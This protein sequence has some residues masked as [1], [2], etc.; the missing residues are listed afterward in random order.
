MFKPSPPSV[1]DPTQPW[2]CSWRSVGPFAQNA[3]KLLE[4]RRV[5]DGL[6]YASIRW[7]PYGPRQDEYYPHTL[8]AGCVRFMDIAVPYQPDRCL[9][10]FGHVQVITNPIMR[11]TAHRPASGIGYEVSV[12]AVGDHLWDCWEDHLVHLSRRSR[13]VTFPGET[14]PDYEDWYNGNS[15]PLIIDPEHHDAPTAHDDVDVTAETPHA[16][17]DQF[18]QA[19]RIG[20]DKKQLSFFRNMM[21]NI[22]PLIDRARH[23]QSTRGPRQTPGD[24]IQRRSLGVYTDSEGEG[25]E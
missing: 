9:R 10:Q 19:Q 2:A 6:T 16:L 14:A 4:Y 7:D 15:R 17:I 11:T 13:P 12:G 20:D 5:L 24:R 21:K 22:Q 23:R 8:F 25:D 3:E 18:A 1:I